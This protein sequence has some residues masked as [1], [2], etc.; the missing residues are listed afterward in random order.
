VAALV[1]VDV[2]AVVRRIAEV[3]GAD[4]RLAAAYLFGSARDRLRPDSDID[5][6]VVPSEAVPTEGW[7]AFALPEE[8]A[9]ALGRWDGHPFEVTVLTLEDPIFAMA[10]L[11]D[12]ELACV[13]D[14][15]AHALFLERVAQWYRRDAYRY[16]RAVAEVNA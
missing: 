5:V 13:T 7:A 1:R 15:E 12:A 10:A 14:P 11:R 16:W 6:A 3:C 9:G 8:V 2:P 4:R